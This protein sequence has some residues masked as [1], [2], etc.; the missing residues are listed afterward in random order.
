MVSPHYLTRA[1]R[2]QAEEALRESEERYR[3]LFQGAAEGILV[4]DIETKK[5]MYANPAQ[6]RMLGYTKEELEQMSISDIH[7]QKNLE[8]V[9]DEFIAQ[10]RGEKK[11]ALSIPCLRKDGSTL[12]ADICP[13]PWLLMEKSA[14]WVF[15]STSPSGSEAS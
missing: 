11:V 9:Q 14:M 6:C 8:R 2:N 7:P 5:F 10:A 4:A 3:D 13:A 1:K 12:Y 15:S